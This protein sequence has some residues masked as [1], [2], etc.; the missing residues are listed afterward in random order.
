MEMGRDLKWGRR[1]QLSDKQTSTEAINTWLRLSD[2]MIL[3]HP[4]SPAAP[5]SPMRFLLISLSHKLI[6]TTLQ[7]SHASQ[8]S[9]ALMR[10]VKYTLTVGFDTAGIVGKDVTLADFK[11]KLDMSDSP[12]VI[13]GF[14]CILLGKCVPHLVGALRLQHVDVV[15]S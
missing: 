12:S 8:P 1:P 5:G 9:L 15:P 7:P 2:K 10:A 4:R 13:I 6:P 14:K 11:A 3:R